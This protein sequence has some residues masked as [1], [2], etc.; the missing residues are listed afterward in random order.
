MR[1]LEM[2]LGI[3]SRALDSL[4]GREAKRTLCCDT[5]MYDVWM[6]KRNCPNLKA[7]CKRI[8]ANSGRDVP[9]VYGDT[10]GFCPD[11]GYPM[12]HHGIYTVG[13]PCSHCSYVEP[14][15]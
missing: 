4:D 3:A 9:P 14:G 11:C 10:E 1:F 12:G 15:R 8:K 13:Q 7:A 2:L 6:H 5:R